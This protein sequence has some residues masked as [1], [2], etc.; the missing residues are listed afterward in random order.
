MKKF[1]VYTDGGSRANPGKAAAA[2]LIYSETGELL[3]KDGAYLGIA[4]NNEAEYQAVK[5]A[6][7][8][9]KEDF[10]ECLPAEIEI[11]ADSQLVVQQLSGSFKVKNPRIKVLYDEVR[12][13]ADSLGK[14]RLTYIPRSK[15]YR[16]DGLVNNILDKEG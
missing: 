15:N 2:Y 8:R 1:V 7:Q 12:Q 5:L 10:S 11:R 13:L 6:L 14:V 3:A 4:T 9:L 16:A